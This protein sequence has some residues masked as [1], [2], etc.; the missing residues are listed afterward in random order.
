MSQVEIILDAEGKEAQLEELKEKYQLKLD[1]E[2]E[3]NFDGMLCCTIIGTAVNIGLFLLQ[4]YTLWGNKRVGLRT[5]NFEA[6]EITIENVL[7]Y[8]RSHQDNQ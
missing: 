7:E 2:A 3:A 1:Y 8:L 4:A 5:Q 6:N